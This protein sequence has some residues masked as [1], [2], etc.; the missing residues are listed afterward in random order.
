M[1]RH[2]NIKEKFEENSV[3]TFTY[4]VEVEKKLP[5]LDA[6]VTRKHSNFLTDVYVKSTNTGQCINYMSIAPH[7]YK[8]GVLKSL[9]ERALKVCGNRTTLSI[10]ISRIKQVLVNNNFPMKL[11]ELECSKFMRRQIHLDPPDDSDPKTPV[12]LF[13]RNQMTTQYKIEES[14]LNKIISDHVIPADGRNIQLHIYY[15]NRHLQQL[16][17]K[18]NPHKSEDESHVVYK[19][20]CP[21]EGCQPLHQYIGYTTN[22][23]KKRMTMHAQ[24]G[25]IIEHQVE[26]HGMRV[27]TRE[28]MESTH[29]IFRASDVK[30][31]K[32]AEALHIKMEKPSINNQREGEA[33]ILQIF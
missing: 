5:F 33:R 7:R 21:R 4:E 11:I 13:F 25:S 26:V 6:C 27:P 20:V 9:M 16:L 2:Y 1:L 3:L 10:E 15:K 29:V 30:E 31:L 14:N 22:P 8:V 18:N 17:I 12:K 19:Y 23:L 24:S 32:I 28:L